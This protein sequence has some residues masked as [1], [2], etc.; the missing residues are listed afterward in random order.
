MKQLF[1]DFKSAKQNLSKVNFELSNEPVIK[2]NNVESGKSI[3]V[4]LPIESIFESLMPLIKLIALH[5]SNLMKILEPNGN[6]T[7]MVSSFGSVITLRM[8][9][10][11]EPIKK[12]IIIESDSIGPIDEN[13][14]QDEY[15]ELRILI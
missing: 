9:Y 15:E 13:E 12:L 3:Y 8:A 2:L 4:L 10:K 7:L 1:I 14:N 6:Y 5:Y 11:N